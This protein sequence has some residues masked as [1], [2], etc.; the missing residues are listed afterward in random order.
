[1]NI[2]IKPELER[3]A[4]SLV[5]RGKYENIEQVIEAAVILLE[6]E[7]QEYEEWIEEVRPKI[8]VGLAQLE[9]GEKMDGDAVIAQL[10][11]KLSRKHQGN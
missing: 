10:Q 6:K 8:E 2:T 1:M 4:L 9:R 7:S 11:K 5:E 3:L